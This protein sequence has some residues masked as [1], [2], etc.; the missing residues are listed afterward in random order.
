M[1]M[2]VFKIE[3]LPN[4]R[5]WVDRDE[6]MLHAC[7]QILKDCVEKEDLLNHCDYKEHKEQVDEARF[8]YEWWLK[9]VGL[10]ECFTVGQHKQDGEMLK[11]LVEIRGFLWT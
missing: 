5:T 1:T 4:A 2:R 3:S 6:I 9:R 8:L 10:D 7:F 11:R